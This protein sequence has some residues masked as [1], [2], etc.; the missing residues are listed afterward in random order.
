[1]KQEPFLPSLSAV[2]QRLTF[3]SGAIIVGFVIVSM[4]L[5]SEWA[6]QTYRILSVQNFWFNIAI[7]PIGLGL[8]AWITFRIFPG[9]ER[10]GIPQVKTA[11]E[12][13]ITLNE[14]STLVSFK[15]AVG[16]LFLSIMDRAVG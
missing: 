12:T 13:S 6:A 3:W 16:K 7:P 14:R 11:L 1:L 5:L 2:T 10:S 9:S 4:T 15:I 8:T